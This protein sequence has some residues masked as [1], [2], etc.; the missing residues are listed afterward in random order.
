MNLVYRRDLPDD[1]QREF[2]SVVANSVARKRWQPS[3][4]LLA[5]FESSGK[6]FGEFVP[7]MLHDLP[8]MYGRNL[9]GLRV[10]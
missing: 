8:E 6:R 9:F 2:H 4:W 3:Y 10:S 1:F 7:L 5:E